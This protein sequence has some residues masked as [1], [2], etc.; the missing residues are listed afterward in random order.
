MFGPPL[1]FGLGLKQSLQ[2]LHVAALLTN[3]NRIENIFVYLK[4]KLLQR[5]LKVSGFVKR[6]K[7]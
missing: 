6:K 3:K 2:K 5:K 4:N 7:G 1:I